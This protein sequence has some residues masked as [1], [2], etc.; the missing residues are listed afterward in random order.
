MAL[1]ICYRSQ[2]TRLTIYYTVNPPRTS[3]PEV[4]SDPGDAPMDLISLTVDVEV[5][6]DDAVS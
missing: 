4:R 2:S 3:Q 5:L 1:S 6:L